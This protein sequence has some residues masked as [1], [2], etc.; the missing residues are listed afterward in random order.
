MLVAVSMVVFGQR[1]ANEVRW[2]DLQGI[3]IT[4]GTNMTVSGS[5]P[6]WTV[7]PS[8]T[9]SLT[10]VTATRGT[11]TNLTSTTATLTT[12]RI[13]NETTTNLTATTATI[14]TLALLGTSTTKTLTTTG[15]IAASGKV[16]S[17]DTTGI[18]LRDASGVYWRIYIS[19]TG[20]IGTATTTTP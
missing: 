12:A 11:V 15:S 14:T 5:Y 2:R 20:V 10:S 4:G 16:S 6:T 18:V 17:A 19:P 8:L 1:G 7:T 9:P 3:T 13:T